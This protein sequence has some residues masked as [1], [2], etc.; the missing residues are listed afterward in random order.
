MFIRICFQVH[1]SLQRATLR[2]AEEERHRVQLE[3]GDR[4]QAVEKLRAKYETLAKSFAGPGTGDGEDGSGGGGSSQ[5][6]Y[7]I[8]AAQK[9][10]ELQREGDELDQEIRKCERE[11]RALEST[12]RHLNAR[13]V[14]FRVS[15]QRADPSSRDAD[16]LRSLEVQA[17]AAQDALFRQKKYLQ[18]LQTDR[19]EYLARLDGTRA[20]AARVYEQNMQLESGRDQVN[21]ELSAQQEAL[22]R[23][24][25]RLAK[26]RGNHR[27]PISSMIDCAS[28]CANPAL[29]TNPP[30]PGSTTKIPGIGGETL[31]E[32][33]LRAGTMRDTASGVL[34]TLGQLAREFP[35][36]HDALYKCLRKKRLKVPRAPPPHGPARVGVSEGRTGCS[37]SESGGDV[38]RPGSQYS[39]RSSKSARSTA[40]VG[41]GD[42]RGGSGS[43]I[44]PMRVFEAP[45]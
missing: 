10:E 38:S 31:T 20:R 34:Y 26:H 4:R 8:A 7:I 25:T 39:P 41:G 42:I 12:L 43:G 21:N 11:I 36:M 29:L 19:E 27:Q 14:D 22:T 9:R 23:A 45:I 1:W 28:N 40:S 3:L 33:V 30:V 32:K 13:N 24:E 35:E 5:A 17:K 16:V 18:R 44:S 2:A 37:S 15:F 6:Y